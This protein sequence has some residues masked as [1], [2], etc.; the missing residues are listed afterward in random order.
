MGEMLYLNIFFVV[1]D[2]AGTTNSDGPK[3]PLPPE[4]YSRS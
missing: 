4:G 1:E 2:V 3:F